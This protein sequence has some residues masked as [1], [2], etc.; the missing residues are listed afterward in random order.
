VLFISTAVRLLVEFR[1]LV[2]V[3]AALRLKAQYFDN[4]RSLAVCGRIYCVN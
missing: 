2:N 1:F 3:A 4:V